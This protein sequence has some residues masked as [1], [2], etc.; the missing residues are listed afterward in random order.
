MSYA[1]KQGAKLHHIKLQPSVAFY[2]HSYI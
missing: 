2:S 1:V